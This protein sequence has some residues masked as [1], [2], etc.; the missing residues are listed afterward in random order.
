M[1]IVF[2]GSSDFAIPSLKALQAG[3]FAPELVV[4]KPDAPRGR[5]RK[6]YDSE[7]KLK[8]FICYAE[9]TGLV[10]QTTSGEHGFLISKAHVVT[11]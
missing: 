9:T 3:G 10:C 2:F 6:I 4:T 8:G 5:G 11:Y 7:V 1:R